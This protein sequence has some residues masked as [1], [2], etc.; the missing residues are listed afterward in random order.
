MEMGSVMSRAIQASAWASKVV[1]LGAVAACLSCGGGSA[2]SSTGST[3]GGSG[4]TS[5]GSCSLAAGTYTI[6]Y[7]LQSGSSTEC[8]VIPDSTTTV[9]ANESA[10]DLMAG[11]MAADAGANCTTVRDRLQRDRDLFS[12]E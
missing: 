8:Q 6:D 4:T 2:S 5:G 1:S 10:S 12:D 11:T 3:N 7:T 9:T